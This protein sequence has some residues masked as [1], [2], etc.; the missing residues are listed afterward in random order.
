[1]GTYCWSNL[2]PGTFVYH[3]GTHPALQ[4]QMG[5]YGAL[6]VD[7][8]AGSC[9]GSRC[10]YPGVAYDRE[11]VAVFSEIDPRVHTQ[12]QNG[13]YGSAV[14]SPTNPE[15]MTSTIFYEPQYFFVD[16][17]ASDGVLPPV[18][19]RSKANVAAGAANQRILLRLVNVGIENH[20]PLLN[21]ERFRPVAQDG[22]PYPA[23]S[24][25]AQYSTLLAAG[26]T[27]DVLLTPAAAGRYALLDRR[28]ALANNNGGA[29]GAAA[30]GMLVNLDIVP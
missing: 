7:G 9:S 24:V 19:F 20:V 23:S 25:H 10:A 1:V 3:S 15:P 22:N 26:K 29:G 2:R 17:E 11:V 13:T 16:G 8:A 6:V 21:G 27:I 5:L 18:A 12:V 14:A 4:V 28:R 30:S